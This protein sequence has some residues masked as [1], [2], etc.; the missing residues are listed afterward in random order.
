M[1]A[2]SGLCTLIYGAGD[3]RSGAAVNLI[4]ITNLILDDSGPNPS[5]VTDKDYT[6]D[7]AG[8]K[9]FVSG[10]LATTFM[11]SSRSVL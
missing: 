7:S 6:F 4:G 10:V 3:I 11:P 2:G 1:S 8:M 5:G 9:Y